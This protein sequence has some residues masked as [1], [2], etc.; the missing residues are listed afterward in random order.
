MGPSRATDV[1]LSGRPELEGAVIGAGQDARSAGTNTQHVSTEHRRHSPRGCAQHATQCTPVIG[2]DVV[3]QCAALRSRHVKCDRKR[4]GGD[5]ESTSTAMTFSSW[6]ASVRTGVWLR[7][8]QTLHDLSYEDE[9]RKSPQSEN[10]TL[11]T[12]LYGPPSALEASD[13]GANARSDM[14]QS[15]PLEN[16]QT[17]SRVDRWRKTRA[18]QAEQERGCWLGPGVCGDGVV[19]LPLSEIPQSAHKAAKP[20]SRKDANP[21]AHAQA[22]VHA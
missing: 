10:F 16:D 12:N 20:Q 14:V 17:W 11:D 21:Q 8:F 13:I 9:N 2:S 7:R 15:R 22:Q 3:T 19:R 18:R 4:R 5:L 6:P 1:Q